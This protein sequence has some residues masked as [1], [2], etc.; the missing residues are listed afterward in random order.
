MTFLIKGCAIFE[1]GCKNKHI[2]YATK[3]VDWKHCGGICD[4]YHYNNEECNHW[5][6]HAPTKICY[7]YDKCEAKT[8][9][10]RD[11]RGPKSCFSGILIY[12]SYF[13]S[14]K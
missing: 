4:R 6:Y 5:R 13:I 7:M 1:E 12:N 14:Y 8:T 3:I 2:T 10:I 11:I 9:D